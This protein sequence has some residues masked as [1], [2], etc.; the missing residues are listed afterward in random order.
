MAR[1]KNRSSHA[2]GMSTARTLLIVA[3]LCLVAIGL[4]M[5]YSTTSVVLAGAGKSP[6]SDVGNQAAFA[7]IGIVA[8][9]VIWRVI[10]YG[11]WAGSF[12]WIVWGVGI[13][14]LFLTWIAGTEVNGAK[15]WLYIGP[16]GMQPSELIKIALLL[17]AIRIMNDMRQGN[18]EVRAAIVQALLLI[19]LPVV[20]LYLTQS[21]L[22]TTLICVVG[23]FAVMWIGGISGK[24]LLGI[25]ALLFIAAAYAIFGTGFRSGRLVYLDPWGDGQNGYGTGYNIIRSYYAL[26]EGGLF[27]VGIGNSHEK[28]D[29]LFASESD[30]IFAVIGEETGLVGALVVVTLF[31]L[32]LYAGLKISEGAPDELGAMIAGGFAIMLVFQAFLNI[33]CTIGVFPTTG[34]PLPFISSGG[35]SIVASLLMVGLILSVERASEMP[36]SHERVRQEFRVHRGGAGGGA[37]WQ[38]RGGRSDQWRRR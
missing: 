12:T 11:A 8:A 3:V 31:L 20:F 21:D 17:M 9:I 1:D 38:D 32:V 35:T 4:L 33:G 26:S 5:V 6:F 37:Q 14:L 19:L 29:Y 16:L 30:F 18:I 23:I 28:F 27:G 15:R 13:V 22:G 7:V 24:W 25:G 10:P 34:K 36:D 2:H